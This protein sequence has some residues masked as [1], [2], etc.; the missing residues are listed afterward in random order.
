MPAM[1]TKISFALALSASSALALS[2]NT[3]SSVTSTETTSITW[4]ST[5]SDPVFSIELD[6]PSFLRPPPSP[7]E[8][9]QQAD[10]DGDAPQNTALAIAN[11]VNPANDNITITIPLVPAQE[12][13]TLTFVN[14]TNINDVFATGSDFAIAVAPNATSTAATGASGTSTGVGASAPGTGVGASGTGTSSGA[15]ASVTAPT[16]SVSASAS[17]SAPSSSSKPSSS[18]RL[19]PATAYVL[20]GLVA[21]ACAL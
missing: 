3:R 21:A 17:N 20:L 7:F 6:H 18:L 10:V 4:S 9:K 8:I 2:I 11:N 12:G 14:V 5:S 19:V 13:Y 16:N 15:K 1:F